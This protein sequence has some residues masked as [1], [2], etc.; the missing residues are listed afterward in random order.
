MT[1]I[2]TMSIKACCDPKTYPI[3]VKLVELFW[4]IF[5]K[6]ALN[7]WM[8]FIFFYEQIYTFI[9]EFINIY[10]SESDLHNC[11]LFLLTHSLQ[12]FLYHPETTKLNAHLIFKHF[13]LMF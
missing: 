5:A 8:N 12:G 11:S 10:V 13:N 7:K 1:D 4:F 2:F 6:K 9:Y 3:A